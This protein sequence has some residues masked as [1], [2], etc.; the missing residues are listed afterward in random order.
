MGFNPW[1]TPLQVY[2]EKT[3]QM[4]PLEDKEAMYWG[5]ESEV[6]VGRRW[7]RDN[8]RK[9][10][11]PPG[12]LGLI[13]H[14]KHEI[15]LATP[16]YLIHNVDE[17][18]EIK[19]AGTHMKHAWGPHGSAEIPSPY[20]IQVQWYMFVCGYPRWHV[21]C[22]IGGRDYRSYTFEADLEFHA[23]MIEKVQEFW[24]R[25]VLPMDPP[26]WDGSPGANEYLAHRYPQHTQR[27]ISLIPAEIED[28]IDTLA[29]ENEKI[30]IATR[31]AEACKQQIKAFMGDAYAIDVPRARI[32]WST[33]TRK[34][35]PTKAQWQALA[36]EVLK[37]LPEDLAT[38]IEA[39]HCAPRKPTQT[40]TFRFT[41]REPDEGE[42]CS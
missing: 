13:R 41:P 42:D 8:K 2:L 10:R 28:A 24:S 36:Q 4:P 33:V 21:A 11:R 19:T 40:R 39:R 37:T 14:P 12:K 9:L 16:D 20:W 29:S 38:E 3:D 18:L 25:H 35:E 26:E 7:A 34:A 23:I 27:T 22:L 5:R 30:Q 6:M 32:S 31:I 15:A 17:G 1:K